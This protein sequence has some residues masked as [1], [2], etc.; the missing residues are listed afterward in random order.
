MTKTTNNGQKPDQDVTI[1]DLANKNG[2]VPFPKAFGVDG[3]SLALIASATTAL[4]NNGWPKKDID[5]FRGLAL[6]GDRNNVINSCLTV[7]G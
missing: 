5:T 1:L 6:S 3:N 7:F 2:R 4:R